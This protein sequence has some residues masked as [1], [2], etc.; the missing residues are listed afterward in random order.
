MQIRSSILTGAIL[1]AAIPAVAQTMPPSKA[2]LEKL[3]AGD[4]PDNPGP[5]A[6]DI[7]PNLDRASIHAAMRKVA[8]W[9]IATGESRFNQLWTFAAL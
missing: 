7:S 5:L 3:A 9:E 4:S 2:N 8:D 6:T 1:F